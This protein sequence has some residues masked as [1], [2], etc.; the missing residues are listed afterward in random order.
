[1]DIE[2][3]KFTNEATHKVVTVT[4]NKLL[5][6]YADDESGRQRFLR[7]MPGTTQLASRAYNRNSVIDAIGGDLT[8]PAVL[9]IYPSHG[10]P[11]Q[12]WTFNEE[13]ASGSGPRGY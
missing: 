5:R 10:G 1:M 11:N 4:S 2:S 7:L 6:Q 3:F 13:D 12:R 9:Q 8:V